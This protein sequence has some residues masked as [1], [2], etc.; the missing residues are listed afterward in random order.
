M[1]RADPNRGR[2]GIAPNFLRMDRAAALDLARRLNTN[3]LCRG[4]EGRVVAQSP[5]PG[6][7][8][9]R[10]GIV[11]LVVAD[12]S[13]GERRIRPDVEIH[14][15]LR[16]SYR[17]ASDREDGEPGSDS[18][19]ESVGATRVRPEAAVAAASVRGR[20]QR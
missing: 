2:R 12:G 5:S 10:D 17:D 6:V 16:E 18:S 3:V 14:E 19:E 9:D 15:R 8:M 13:G 1:V 7:P 20:R 11:R 4:D